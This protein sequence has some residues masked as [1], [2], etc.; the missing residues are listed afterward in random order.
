MTDYQIEDE[1]K[2]PSMKW[3]ESGSGD[4]GRIYFEVIGCEGLPNYDSGVAGNYSDAFCTVVYEDAIVNTDVINDCLSPR[5][6]PWTRR[7]FVFNIDHPSS[8]I[9]VGVFDFD[10]NTA[11]NAHD[12]MG[13]VTIDITSFAPNTEY[14][15]SYNLFKT[16]LYEDRT[17]QGKL[18]VRL[19]IELNKGVNTRTMLNA[20]VSQPPMNFI[21]VSKKNDF[22]AAYFVCHGQEDPTKLD[23]KAF[24]SYRHEFEYKKGM[25]QYY[26]TEATKTIMFWRGHHKV[27]LCWCIRF[28]IPIHS[29]IAFSTSIFVVEDFNLLPAYFFFCIAW[30]MFATNG[31][32]QRHPSK[33]NNT[34]SCGQIWWG[35]TFGNLWPQSVADSERSPLIG[36]YDAEASRVSARIT[37]R[38][39]TSSKKKKGTDSDED[40]DRPPEN[41]LMTQFAKHS[42][43]SANSRTQARMSLNP[44]KPIILPF[45]K[46]IGRGASLIRIVQ[47][48]VTWDECYYAFVVTHVSLLLALACFWVPW[49]FVIR[50]VLRIAVWVFLGPW[51]KVLDWVFFSKLD[52]PGDNWAKRFRDRQA[53]SGFLCAHMRFADLIARQFKLYHENAMKLRSMKKYLFGKFVV[54][55]PR[56]KTFRFP[57]TPLPESS[58]TPCYPGFYHYKITERKHGQGLVGDM[59][60]HW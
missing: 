31:E 29:I 42:P 27:R 36:Q 52:V 21:N 37:K 4:L 13:R 57:D 43:A 14:N 5:W 19:R 33:W 48:I 35:L 34:L 40:D 51:M 20:S 59:I 47:S 50:W 23:I 38:I 18:F 12:P 1:A 49:C 22:K 6:M 9:M 15:L 25:A 39:I 53:N 54:A 60:P 11:I 8:Q 46:L 3:I 30:F 44:L 16:N 58:A 24:K 2:K 56:F 28:G 7:A 26:I 32:R 17:S 55:V 10:S 41:D 45:Q